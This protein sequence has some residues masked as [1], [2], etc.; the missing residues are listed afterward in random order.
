[1]KASEFQWFS[2]GLLIGFVAI[3]GCAPI[4]VLPIDSSHHF[5][6]ICINENRSV[7]VPDFVAI[8]QEGFEL[9]GIS[10]ELV[11]GPMP[12]D[13]EY[14]VNYTARRSWDI[15]LYLTQAQIDIQRD[16]RAIA[17]ASYN[18]KGTLTRGL[19]ER[20]DTREKILPLINTLLG[21]P[22]AY[23]H[24]IVTSIESPLPTPRAGTRPVRSS[25]LSRRLSELKDALDAGLIT[26]QEYDAKRKALLDEL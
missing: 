8:M 10:S 15:K 14:S 1:M 3:T 11:T 16:G 6:H 19:D 18:L 4:K 21:K 26:Q 12:R 5:N 25:E 22:P 2:A 7:Q 24:S 9:N 20:A 17:S 13:C 23:K